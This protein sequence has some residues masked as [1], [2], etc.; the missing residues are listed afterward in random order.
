MSAH[1]RS[2]RRLASCCLAA[3]TVAALLLAGCT[4]TV[5]GAG[6]TATPTGAPSSRTPSASSSS[7][8]APAPAPANFTDCGSLFNLKDLPFPA[9]RAKRLSFD[10]ARLQVPLNHD[11]ESGKSIAIEVIRVHDSHNTSGESLMVNPGG[12]GGSGVELAVGL[13]IQVSDTLLSHYDLLGFDPRGVGLSSPVSCISDDEK[14][15]LNAAAPD[16]LTAT[17]LAE[18]KHLAEMVA[19]KCNAKYGSSLADYNTVQTA[20]DMEQIRGAVGNKPLN[21]LGFSYG[22]E[23][24]SIYAHL[25]PEHVRAA[26]LDG[27]VDPLSD[28]LTSFADQ[29]KGFEGAFDQFQANCLTRAACKK[30]GNPRQVVYDLAKQA[31]QT[32]LTS[33]KSGEHRTA[34]GSIVLTGVLSALYSQSDWPDLGQAL[35]DAKGGDAKGLFKLA[36][37]YNQR[38]PDGH[39]SNISE[40]NTTVNCNDAKPGPSDETIKATAIKWAKDYPMFGRWSAPSLFSCQVWQADRTPVPLPS[41]PTVNKVLVIGNLHDPATPYKG[42]VDLAQAMGNAAL[43]SWDGEG[44]TSFLQGSHCIDDYVEAY[45][46]SGTVPPPKKTCPR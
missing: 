41:A 13:A 10:C 25:Y 43:L 4:A 1:R 12:P 39:Y 45:L 9:G 11:D 40:A 28:D 29:L 35:I 20:R 18:A 24:G 36:D 33:S 14:D 42:A 19:T 17:G 22:T 23:L 38:G 15:Q 3:A 44:H 31:N 46:I 27:A 8:K 5:S 6:S 37:S 7:A 32:P 30:L 21:Y 2:R 34:T 26:V 16:V